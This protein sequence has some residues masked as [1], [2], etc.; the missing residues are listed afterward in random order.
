MEEKKRY[1]KESIV[2]RQ[3]PV[4]TDVFSVW[5]SCR[6]ISAA[7]V[8]GQFVGVYSRDLSRMLPRP[9][10]LCEID[11]VDGAIRLVY[12]VA[13]KG[14]EELSRLHTGDIVRLIGPLGNGY[15]IDEEKYKAPVL[16]GG[17][18]GIP[19]L[20]ELS[21]RLSSPEK[22]VVLGYKN[23]MFLLDEFEASGKRICIAMENGLAGIRGFVTD[24]IACSNVTGDVVYACGP[25]PM[26][27]AVKKY[28]EDLGVP[29]Y[30]SLEE[31]MACGVGACLGCV[32]KTNDKDAHSNVNNARICTEG[33]V[34]LA[35][36]VVL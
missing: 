3:E 9:I 4:S 36:E 12:R 5:L 26:L 27:R 25:M 34:F 16:I 19:P 35:S 28:A 2:I 7:A 6:E 17:G 30:V 18:V 1:S 20:L 14:T 31:H 23:E 15:P 24:A 33:P 8:P 10:S 32:V 13:G 22:T 29:A 11:A 21:K